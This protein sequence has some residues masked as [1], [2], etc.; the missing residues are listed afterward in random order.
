MDY[1]ELRDIYFVFLKHD[2]KY[3]IK[4]NILYVGSRLS[5]WHVPS[6]HDN[7]RKYVITEEKWVM[8]WIY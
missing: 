1:K 5:N 6:C 2:M 4:N 8:D 7:F 3:F